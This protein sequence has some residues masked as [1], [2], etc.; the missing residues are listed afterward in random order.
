MSDRG[1]KI[2]GACWLVVLV[3]FAWIW[4]EGWRNFTATIGAPHG[5]QH[6]KN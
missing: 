4:V 3:A 2:L 6:V 5:V 1:R